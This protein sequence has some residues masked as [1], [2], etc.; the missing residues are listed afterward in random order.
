MRAA[1][2]G[3]PP[4]VLLVYFSR[5]RVHRLINS[6]SFPPRII[7]KAKMDDLDDVLNDLLAEDTGEFSCIDLY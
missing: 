5:I 3:K 1:S 7:A 2:L 6:L 4:C